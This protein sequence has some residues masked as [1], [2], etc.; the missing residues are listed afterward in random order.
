MA[1]PPKPFDVLTLLFRCAEL[2]GI[3][4][5]AFKLVS[6][7]IVSRPGGMMET[8]ERGCW[9]YPECLHVYGDRGQRLRG[10]NAVRCIAEQRLSIQAPA[11]IVDIAPRASR[12]CTCQTHLNLR[13]TAQIAKLIGQHPSSDEE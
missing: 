9:M 7:S 2:G 10:E 12:E 8:L 6:G 3:D 11:Q 13:A 1:S 4:Q 5:C